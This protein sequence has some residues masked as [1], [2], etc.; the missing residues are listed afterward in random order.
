MASSSAA[1]AD[2]VLPERRTYWCDECDMSVAI[3]SSSSDPSPLICPQCRVEFLQGMDDCSFFDVSVGDFDDDDE[4]EEEDWC[5]VDPAVNSDDNFLLDSPY[6]Q[7][8][9]RHLASESSGSS[10]SSSK[11]P[12]IDSIP[13]V[14]ISSSMLCSGDDSDSCMLCAVCKEEFEVGESARRLPCTHLYH[15]DCI[16]PWLSDHNSCPLCR[17][18]LPVAASVGR[19][20]ERRIRLS[21][22]VAMEGDEVEDGG[23]DGDGDGDDWSG[24]GGA[25]RRIARRHQQR[26]RRLGMGTVER[27]IS[28]TVSGLRVDGIR[29]ENSDTIIG[30]I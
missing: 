20:A 21:D 2:G 29:E 27:E 5:L 19:E 17:F 30:T 28:L 10:S 9:L 8:L 23:G 24:I 6:L 12:D 11:S 3:L 4:E 18:E 1:A 22:L 13:T 16:I 7:R 14:Q 25:L 26:R 15:S